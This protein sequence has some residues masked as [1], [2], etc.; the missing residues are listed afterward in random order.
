MAKAKSITGLKRHVP[1]GV[2]ARIIALTRL[3]ELYSWVEYVD[4]PYNIYELHNLRIA[5]KRLRY[6]RIVGL[7]ICIFWRER[8]GYVQKVTTL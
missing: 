7:G 1:T 6:T 5:A 4:D 3:E 8:L 2:N